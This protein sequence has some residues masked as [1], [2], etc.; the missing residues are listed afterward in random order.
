MALVSV[1][2]VT[3]LFGTHVGL[4]D[5]S[6]DLDTGETAAVFGSN[7]A[8]KTTLVRILM[9]LSRPTDGTVTLAGT[10]VDG[11]DAVRSRIGAVTHE[12]MLYDDLTARENLR[13]HARLHGADPDACRRRLEDVGLLDRADDRVSG[14]SHGMRKRV[15]LARA[16]VHDP[17]LLLLD[18]PYSGLD[19]RSLE[20]VDAVLRDLEDRSVL[21][22]THDVEHGA[23][24]A[25]RLLFMN[26]GRL[27]EDADADAFA[28]PAAVRQR[29]EDRCTGGGSSSSGGGSSQRPGRVDARGR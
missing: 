28:D 6:F 14:F 27:V 20:R 13:V 9:S 11:D 12:T 16:L 17:D 7:G 5:V 3:K 2:G 10:P 23:A 26:D 25:D 1:S 18:E 22:T 29:Y 19:Q 15:S 4:D 21:L 24:L 8:G